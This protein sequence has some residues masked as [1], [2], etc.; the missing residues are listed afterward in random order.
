MLKPVKDQLRRWRN[1]LRS[2]GKWQRTDFSSVP[3]IFGNA[4]PK[5]GSHL[6]LQVL[7]GT[8]QIAPLRH[9]EQAPVRMITAKGRKRS[10]REIM[11]DLSRLRAGM[12][13][14]GYLSADPLFL[15][16]FHDHPQIAV[17]FIYRDPRDQ[18]ISS[19]FY[20]VDIHK[21][22]ALHHYYADISFDDRI[23]TAIQGR[24][25]PGLEH[26]P[27]IRDQYE[28]NLAWLD[29]PEILSLKFED[30]IHTPQPQIE[31]IL[32]LLISKGLP[33]AVEREAAIEVILEAIQP[34]KS[35]TF[36]KG[37]SGGW[38]KHF[39]DEHKKLFKDIT[40]DLLIRL[41][42]EKDNDW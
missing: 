12:V 42:Y 34:E 23:K 19:I 5:S 35:P 28:R 29:H 14:W 24:D 36:R 8:M 26:L 20:A 30:M 25:V 6:L 3:A 22:H 1:S 16:F 32:D 40:G 18:L 41:G 13:E 31:R 37:T 39:T 17:F 9:L 10:N 21:E 38:R 15:D 27:N 33:V 4:M 11:R 2:A 7:E